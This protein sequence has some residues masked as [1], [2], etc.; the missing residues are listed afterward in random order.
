MATPNDTAMQQGPD[1]REL[2]Q[3]VVGAIRR[4]LVRVVFTTLLFVMLGAAVVMIWPEKYESQTS[5]NMNESKLVLDATLSDDLADVPLSRKMGALQAQMQSL[6][7]ITAVMDELQWEEWLETGRNPSRRRALHRKVKDNF[8]IQLDPDQSSMITATFSFQWTTPRQAA[9]FVN[10]A[11]DHFI[12][13]VQDNSRQVA[14]SKLDREQRNLLDLEDEHRAA[15]E[16]IRTYEQENDVAS[17]LD[18]P[19]NNSLKTDLIVRLSEVSAKRISA[20]TE[21]GLLEAELATIPRTRLEIVPPDNEAQATALLELQTAQAAF[22]EIAGTY[23]SQHY[24]YLSA[25]RKLEDAKSKLEAAGGT[26][27]IEYEQVPNPPYVTLLGELESKRALLLEYTTAADRFQSEL[28]RIESN[29][30]RLPRV[31]A[32]MARLSAEEESAREILA[33]ARIGIQPLRDRVKTLRNAA[34]NSAT[35]SVLGGRTFEILEEGIEPETA[36]LPIGAII[37]AVSLLLGIALGLTG[38]VLKEMTRSSFGSVK[39]VSR[40][41]GVPVL[42]AVDL[43][44]TSRDVRARTVQSW[45]TITAMVLVLLALGTFLYLY[46]TNP[47][48]LP[49]G[50]GRAVRDLQ[51]ALT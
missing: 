48:V 50:V 39:E 36:V 13:L 24:K 9:A 40:S 18:S 47:G 19:A 35:G 3:K 21:V 28:T 16:A 1:A 22:D 11:R 42:G 10:R 23:T 5:F 41:L 46:S 27:E 7:R 8:D 14:E 45:L 30:R 33:L 29:L 4:N 25:E 6:K 26:P 44:L 15:L 32:D 43:I 34:S 49:S 20:V 17:L 2:I 38:P 31:T 51:L 37:M 12:K